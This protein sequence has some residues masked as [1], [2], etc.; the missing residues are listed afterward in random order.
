MRKIAKHINNSENS[1]Q[2]SGK[3]GKNMVKQPL[4]FR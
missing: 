1:K 4:K 2:M 3:S